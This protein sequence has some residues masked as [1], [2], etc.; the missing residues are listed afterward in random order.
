MPIKRE[1]RNAWYYALPE[2]R[3]Q[4][5]GNRMY[6]AR[7]V[8]QWILRLVGELARNIETEAGWQLHRSVDSLNEFTSF[9]RPVDPLSGVRLPTYTANKLQGVQDSLSIR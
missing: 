2:V 8:V 4:S 1:A 5:K 6:L 3:N 7:S 9:D